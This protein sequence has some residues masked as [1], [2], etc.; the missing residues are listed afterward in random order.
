MS[1]KLVIVE[2]PAKA[3]TIRNILGPGY[4]VLA[5]MGHIRDLPRKKL[6]VDVE[7]DF[8]PHYVIAPKKRSVVRRLQEA[9]RSAGAVYLATD[10]DRE[11]EAIAWHVL[12]C[13]KLPKG[14]PVYRVTFHEITPAAIRAAFQQAGQLNHALVEAQ[15]TRRILDRL[16]GYQISPLLWRR[17]K[18]GKGLSAGRVQTIALRLVVDR[19][20][21][22][23]AFEPEEYWTIEALL[24]QHISNP[25]PFLAQLYRIGK[26][27]P[28]LKS[29]DDVQA[30]L[31]ALEGAVYWVERVDSKRQRRRPPP[32]FTTSTLQQA[33]SRALKLS[34]R[35]TMSIAQQL[36]EGVSLGDE[37]R[38]GLITYMRTD[39]TAVAPEAQAAARQVILQ[40]FGAGYL[41]PRPPVYKTRVK[42][43]QEAHEAIRPTDVTRTPRQVRPYLDE[44]QDALYT[45]IWR[46]FVASQMADALYEVTTALIPTGRG[47][48]AD[49]LPYL[50]RARGRVCLFDGFLCVYEEKLDVGQEAEKEQ[51]LPPLRA[52]EDLDLLELI[53]RQ[54]WTKPPPRYTEASLIKELERRGIGRPSTFATMVNL[55][56]QRAYVRHQGRVLVPTELGMVVCDLLVGFFADLFDYGFTA[57]MEQALDDIANGRRSRLETLR[58]FW[59]DL[60]PVLDKARADMPRVELSQHGARSVSKARP[61][62]TGETCP[63]CGGQ[64][65]RRQG[66]YGPF[67]G[68]A[69]F[70]KCR[71]T[72]K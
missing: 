14:V 72:R 54:H 22:I 31:Q 11:G 10:M 43:A 2:S 20:R 62:P 16:V 58:R 53:P 5:S 8:R 48:R 38:V 37:G 36:Y 27:K 7:N 57:Q 47:G 29:R 9:A 56:Q 15:Q 67:V 60:V 63:Q 24:A 35:R 34:P 69:N 49:R 19:E 1:V 40:Y 41:P 4:R 3:K 51:P 55:I 64:L 46:R 70:P 21:E 59:D 17:V 30:I 68:C 23:E 32:P 52:G 33:A 65:V 39:S 71:Y 18:G 25:T 61:E 13:L 66:R 45:L 12:R 28:D 50:F 42:S 44:K 6:G 26:D